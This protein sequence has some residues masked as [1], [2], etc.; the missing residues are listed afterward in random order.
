M[1]AHFRLNVFHDILPL[2]LLLL[3]C[4]YL[5][6]Q[7]GCFGSNLEIVKATA[8]CP[9]NVVYCA[10]LL[11]ETEYLNVVLGGQAKSFPIRFFFCVPVR[12]PILETLTEKL[13]ALD[14]HFLEED[15]HGLT[16]VTA[17]RNRAD[18][19]GVNARMRGSGFRR[20]AT[21]AGR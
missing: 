1:P 8:P 19:V 5:A 15:F 20:V 6:S 12:F 10:D 4:L 21:P 13:N 14:L 18:R 3:F 7:L 2:L 11:H 17:G 16:P 9:M